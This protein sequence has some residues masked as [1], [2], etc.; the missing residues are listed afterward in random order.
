MAAESCY[1]CLGRLGSVAIA[2][3]WFCVK[4]DAMI[5][6]G[7][8]VPASEGHGYCAQAKAATRHLTK[9]SQLFDEGFS[10]AGKG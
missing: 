8:I 7:Q 3:R 4:C 5:R 6:G 10:V 1:C 2:D 9:G